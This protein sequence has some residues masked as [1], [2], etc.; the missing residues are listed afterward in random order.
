MVD[1]LAMQVSCNI[2]VYLRS[3]TN[4][5][6]ITVMKNLSTKSKVAAGVL[7][8][9]EQDLVLRNDSCNLLL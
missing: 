2:T 9:D 4:K 3:I 1:V 6:K 7:M 8:E 5:F